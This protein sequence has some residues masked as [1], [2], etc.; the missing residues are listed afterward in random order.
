LAGWDEDGV[1]KEE[2]FQKY[3]LSSEWQVF[4]KK[5]KKGGAARG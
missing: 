2:T 1:P 3:G 5:M 4:N